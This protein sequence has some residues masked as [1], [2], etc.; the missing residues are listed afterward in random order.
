MTIEQIRIKEKRAEIKK[1]QKEMADTL[2]ISQQAY[3]QL[4]TGRT[5]DMRISTLK[6]LCKIFNVSADW[7]LGLADEPQSRD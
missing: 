2:G 7:L 1:T 5:A 4:E 3:Q 6:K